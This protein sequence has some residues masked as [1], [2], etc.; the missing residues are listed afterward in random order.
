MLL[1]NDFRNYVL[2][3]HVILES[4]FVQLFATTHSKYNSSLSPN[5][6]IDTLL[7]VN[8]MALAFGQGHLLKKSRVSNVER[9]YHCDFSFCKKRIFCDIF[10]SGQPIMFQ[11][12]L[13]DELSS[14]ISNST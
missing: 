1:Q 8:L 3:I 10:Y 13:P 5:V 4:H 12:M 11:I 9:R 14:N 7:H 6:K 2:E